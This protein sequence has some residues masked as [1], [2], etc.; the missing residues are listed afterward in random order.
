MHNNKIMAESGKAGR[1]WRASARKRIDKCYHRSS[2]WPR[3]YADWLEWEWRVT[4]VCVRVR[5][6]MKAR[7]RI[8]SQAQT[9]FKF[10]IRRMSEDNVHVVCSLRRAHRAQHRVSTVAGVFYCWRSAA[11]LFALLRSALIACI[12]LGVEI[13]VRK[14]INERSRVMT[15]NIH[16]MLRY[17]LI[18]IKMIWKWIENGEKGAD[19]K[20]E[21]MNVRGTMSKMANNY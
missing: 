12:N 1:R 18:K 16:L 21:H 3:T 8:K 17:V 9:N 15:R 4:N 10:D 19:A 14:R 6:A 7:N 13:N 20:L 11:W 2:L 5:D